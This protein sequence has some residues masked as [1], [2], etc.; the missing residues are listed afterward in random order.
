MFTEITPHAYHV[1]TDGELSE[2][3]RPT[4]GHAGLHGSELACSNHT[5]RRSVGTDE[6]ELQQSGI[7]IDHSTA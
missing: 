2:S 6:R 4:T 5:T 1:A 3:A 7:Q